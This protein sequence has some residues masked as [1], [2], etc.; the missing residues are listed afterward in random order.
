M[1]VKPLINVIFYIYTYIKSGTAQPISIWQRS[2]GARWTEVD[3][4]MHVI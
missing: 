2:A 4:V 1:K 3:V